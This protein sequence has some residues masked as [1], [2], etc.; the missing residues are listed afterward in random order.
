[1]C[2]GKTGVESI[3]YYDRDRLKWESFKNENLTNPQF[4]QVSVDWLDEEWT[5]CKFD[6][7]IVKTTESGEVAIGW[8]CRDVI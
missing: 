6:E 4:Q 8:M 3:Y 1:M 2:N 5:H 7:L